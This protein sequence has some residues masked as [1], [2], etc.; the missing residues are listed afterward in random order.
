MIELLPVIEKERYATPVEQEMLTYFR[1]VIYEPLL[2]LLS[3]AERTNAKLSALLAA[4]RGGQVF[5]FKGKFSGRFGP[6]VA[7]ELRSLGARFDRTNREFRINPDSLP[8]DVRVAATDAESHAA[9][10]HQQVDDTLAQMQVNLPKAPTGLDFEAS[11]ARMVEDLDSQFDRSVKPLDALTVRVDPAMGKKVADQLAGDLNLSVKGFTV[12]QVK[13]L[14]AQAAAN[15]FSGAR[16]DRLR[17]IIESSYGVTKRKAAFLANQETSLVT[18]HY[19]QA[20]FQSVGSTH[21]RWKTMHDNS[22]RGDHRDL[23]GHVFAWDSPPVENKATGHRA[24]PG[25]A[26]GCRCRACAIISLPTATLL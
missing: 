23:D 6:A 14:R 10:L 16:S 4:L 2:R 11:A 9:A 19:R 21:Y 15:A 5:Y 20:R 24:N 25:E 22:V 13:E 1:E 17:R 3:P 12:G 7:K 18:A 8:P 26:Y